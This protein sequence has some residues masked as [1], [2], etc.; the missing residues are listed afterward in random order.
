MVLCLKRAASAA[1]L[2]LA[3]VAPVQAAQTYM[4]IAQVYSQYLYDST[5]AGTQVFSSTL[6][7]STITLGDIITGQFSYDPS[8]TVNLP[9]PDPQRG[10]YVDFGAQLNFI[11][12]PSGLTHQ[13]EGG[14]S[15]IVVNDVAGKDQIQIPTS[16]HATIGATDAQW[17]N[18]TLEDATGTAL[19]STALPET[20]DASKFSTRRL[21]WTF[22]DA[23]NNQL[24]VYASVAIFQR[25]A[26]VPEPESW[27]MLLAGLVLIGLVRRRYAARAQAWPSAA[28]VQS[29][30]RSLAAYS[31][32]SARRSMASKVSA[33][34]PCSATPAL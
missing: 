13:S 6:S 11:E 10:F 28:R 32:R 29:R 17:V 25:V 4:F 8:R 15:V 34:P 2:A 16:S 1:L 30:P 3:V 5:G 31:W 21:T 20:L 7:G 12:L 22:S 33:P 14:A 26:A 27:G 9:I 18:I 23:A 24:D 19:G